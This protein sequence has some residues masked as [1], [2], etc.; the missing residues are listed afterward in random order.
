MQSGRLFV[1][2][3]WARRLMLIIMV[4]GVLL[5]GVGV[6][7]QELVGWVCLDRLLGVPGL[8]LPLRLRLSRCRVRVGGILNAG[9]Y[10]RGSR[11]SLRRRRCCRRRPSRPVRR[12]WWSD[13]VSMGCLDVY[14]YGF[15]YGRD[16]ALHLDF[17]YAI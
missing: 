3:M 6:L 17:G 4:L 2:M 13:L 1:W 9:V 15:G 16:F 12:F 10:S 11:V 14:G 8:V 7:R 5:L